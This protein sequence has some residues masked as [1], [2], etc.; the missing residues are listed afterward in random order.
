[1]LSKLLDSGEGNSMEYP[2]LI[3]L[4]EECSILLM[5]NVMEKFYSTK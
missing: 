3:K 4:L 5:A 1:M 2:T